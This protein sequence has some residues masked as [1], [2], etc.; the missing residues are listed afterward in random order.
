MSEENIGDKLPPRVHCFSG[1][2]V[3]LNDVCN[4]SNECSTT[5]CMWHKDSDNLQIRRGKDDNRTEAMTRTST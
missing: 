3:D 2:R 4:K 5:R 1:P